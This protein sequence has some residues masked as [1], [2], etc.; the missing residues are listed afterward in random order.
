MCRVKQPCCNVEEERKCDEGLV[1]FGIIIIN[2]S[3][4]HAFFCVCRNCDGDKHEVKLW[5]GW[6]LGNVFN[7]VSLSLSLSCIYRKLILPC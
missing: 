2:G 3:H 1:E 5:S 7:V 6:W 4:F